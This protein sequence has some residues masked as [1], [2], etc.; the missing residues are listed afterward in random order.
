MGMRVNTAKTNLLVVSDAL[1]YD[2]VA[3]IYDRDGNRIESGVSMKVLG[4]HMDGRPSVAALSSPGF[5]VI[6]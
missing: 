1:T 5:D 6:N 4:F 3:E 2:P